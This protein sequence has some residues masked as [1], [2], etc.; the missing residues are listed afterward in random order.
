MKVSISALHS[1]LVKF[2]M[3]ACRYVCVSYTFP[4]GGKAIIE[5]TEV[6]GILNK[7]ENVD[8][9]SLNAFYLH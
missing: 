2:G 7:Y 9:S 8:I 5:V 1:L 3:C 4:G 6:Q